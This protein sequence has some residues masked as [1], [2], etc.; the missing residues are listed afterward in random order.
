M[1][2]KVKWDHVLKHLAPLPIV[3][4]RYVEVESYPDNWTGRPALLEAFGCMPGV[5][6]QRG[7]MEKTFQKVAGNLGAW[8]LWGCDFPMFAMT[9]ARLGKPKAAVDMLLVDHA[10]NRYLPNGHMPQGRRLEAYLPTNGGLL[11]A[12]ALMAAGW[13]GGPAGHA[14]GFPANGQWIVRWEGLHPAP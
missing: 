1:P 7:P 13:D 14:P 3:D 2:R 9:A 8:K 12:V 11:W 10:R 6:V 4:G 5:R